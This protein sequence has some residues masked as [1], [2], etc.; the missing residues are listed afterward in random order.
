M[1]V[2]TK[3]ILLTLLLILEEGVNTLLA[4]FHSPLSNEVSSELATTLGTH[5]ALTVPQQVPW[6]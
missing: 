2:N 1:C 4:Q 3:D 6:H 5:W